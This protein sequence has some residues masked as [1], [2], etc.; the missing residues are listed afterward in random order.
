M[1]AQDS[2][3]LQLATPPAGAPIAI[4]AKR[5]G[6]RY[7]TS[8]ALAGVD[9]AI[10]RGTTVLV[11]G[12]NGSGKSTLF[13]V[14]AG[15]LS[16]DM[17]TLRIEGCDAMSDRNGLRRHVAL[18]THNTFAYEQLTALENLRVAARLLGQ[19]AD[20]KRLVGLLDEMGIGA[21]ADDLVKTFSAGM[22]K[23]LAFARVLLQKPSV[24]LLDEPYAQLDP[25][26]LHFVDVLVPRLRAAGSTVLVAEH[27]LERGAELC[28]RGIVLDRG[29][30]TW[31]GAARDLPAQSGLAV[32]PSMT[33]VA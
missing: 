11:A 27:L 20:R 26:G 25:Q 19:D 1:T 33:R 8:W 9:L 29:R 4:E 14:L 12:R 13:R 30:I 17:G 3:R 7:G 2:A 18:L 28:E 31:S 6:R 24:V 10:P 15:A 21:R 23:R 16:P 22:R 5:L 32:R